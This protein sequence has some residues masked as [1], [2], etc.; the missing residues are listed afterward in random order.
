MVEPVA[1]IDVD[2]VRERVADVQQRI[3][4]SLERAGRQSGTVELVAAVKYVPVDLVGLLA[5]TGIR[6]LGENRAQDLS[7]KQER[8]GESFEWDFI[9]DL[10]SRKVASLIGRTRL[11]HSVGSRSALAKLDRPEQ[12]TSEFSCKSMSLVRRVSQ[13]LPSLNC[14]SFLSWRRARWLV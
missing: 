14:L 5:E 7:E 13:G 6:I 4:A 3:D 1:S 12:R 9:G 11:I 8:W 10:Q 2:V